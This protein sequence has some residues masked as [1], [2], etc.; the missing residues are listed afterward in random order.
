MN[1]FAMKKTVA[2][3]ALTLG[4]GLLVAACSGPSTGASETPVGTWGSEDGAFLTLSEDGGLSGNDGCNSLAGDW[5]QNGETVEFGEVITTLMACEDVDTWL[6]GLNTAKVD[7]NELRIFDDA[8][9]E[10]GSLPRG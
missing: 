7:G 2:L 8:G 3:T 6:S 9:A 10:I 1:K 5:E 4:V